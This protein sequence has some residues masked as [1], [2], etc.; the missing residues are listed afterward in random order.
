[1]HQK[2][3]GVSLI[4]VLL[5]LIIVSLLGVASI[6]VSRMATQS[7]R[8]ERDTQ[9]AWQAAEAALLDAELDILG[10]PVGATN[11]RGEIFINS[12]PDLS[13]FID[14]CGSGEKNKGLCTVK[15]GSIPAWLSIDFLQSDTPKY[16][17]FGEFTGRSFLSGAQGIQPAHA[18]RYIIELF[19][20]PNTERTNSATNRKYIYRVTAIGFGPNEKTQV[21]LQTIYRN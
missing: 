16:V 17:S 8:N 19:D 21:V 2:N 6:Q 7:A 13:Q 4:V 11:T 15:A 12:N 10:Q 5:I 9:I 20:D 18:P 1:M 3:K 14:D